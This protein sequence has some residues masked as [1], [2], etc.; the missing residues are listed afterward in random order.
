MSVCFTQESEVLA[1]IEA[2]DYFKNQAED[3]KRPDKEANSTAKAECAV[4]DVFEY[5]DYDG[6]HIRLEKHPNEA[7]PHVEVFVEGKSFWT[8]I[9]T[10][11]YDTG[12]LTCGNKG[13]SDVPEAYREKLRE[14][15]AA[16]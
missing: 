15:L 1:I 5:Q 12:R 8:G 4:D 2:K 9:P 16:I 13:A 10:F 3:D 14:Y 11:S 6:E 7:P